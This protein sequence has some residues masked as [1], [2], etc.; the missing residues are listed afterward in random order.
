MILLKL[1]IVAF[2][3]ITVGNRGYVK[4]T[5]NPNMKVSLY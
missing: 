1:Q 5:V 3:K 2:A 4:L